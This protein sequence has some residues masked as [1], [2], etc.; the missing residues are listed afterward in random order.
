MKSKNL[1]LFSPS[2]LDINGDHEYRA[3]VLFLFVSSKGGVSFFA[4]RKG[5]ASFVCVKKW[6]KSQKVYELLAWSD[7]PILPIFV[8]YKLNRQNFEK[9]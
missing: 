7:I 6:G 8:S 5:G 3:W 1:F 2:I 9:R 4:G